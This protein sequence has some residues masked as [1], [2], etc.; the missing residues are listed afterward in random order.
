MQSLSPKFVSH[1]HA[2]DGPSAAYTA[3]EELP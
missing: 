2:S 3:G 1:E